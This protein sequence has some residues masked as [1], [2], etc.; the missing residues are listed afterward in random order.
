MKNRKKLFY[1]IRDPQ[2]VESS[3]SD[4]S[5]VDHSSLL[6]T[7]YH[8][9]SNFIG[10]DYSMENSYYSETDEKS[11]LN[12]LSK[13]TQE[14]EKSPRREE[15]SILSYDGHYRNKGKIGYFSDKHN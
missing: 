15:V 9:M 6:Y 5:S 8:I 10:C 3:N 1:Y 12:V 2:S 13:E 11:G 7:D 14:K 4:C